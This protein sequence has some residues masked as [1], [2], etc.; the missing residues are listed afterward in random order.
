MY[1]G[2][3][4]IKTHPFFG[5]YRDGG[6]DVLQLSPREV[7]IGNLCHG[8][9]LI[10]HESRGE[11]RPVHGTGKTERHLARP[12]D[13]LEGKHVFVIRVVDGDVACGLTQ[14]YVCFRAYV[15]LHIPVPVQV[16]GSDVEEHGYIGSEISRPSN[17]KL[18]ASIT[19]TSIASSLSATEE[20]AA[21]RLPTAWEG[22]R[23]HFRMWSMR[24]VVVVL[25]LVPVTAICS[26]LQNTEA[27]SNSLS[28]LL[29]IQSRVQYAGIG[30]RHPRAH[31][32]DVAL[33]EHRSA[34]SGVKFFWVVVV[35][36]RPA[37]VISRELCGG[38]PAQ[39][40]AVHH[41]GLSHQ[42]HTVLA[43]IRVS[44]PA[45]AVSTRYSAHIPGSDIPFISRW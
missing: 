22:M 31:H 39:S 14:E 15:P 45:I 21:P 20:N 27:N 36:Y 32:Q 17:W 28:H 26:A 33:A 24:R 12:D 11:I 6:E 18:E 40:R 41:D 37:A 9:P 10:T 8:H 34:G 5:G 16:V 23:A 44:A 30:G 7:D 35:Y 25:P 4:G 2:R 3:N 1:R 13:G 43:K 38:D 29:A 42:I 19:A